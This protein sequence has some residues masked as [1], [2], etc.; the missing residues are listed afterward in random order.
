MQHDAGTRPPPDRA[1][2]VATH[3]LSTETKVL[4]ERYPAVIMPLMDRPFIQHVIEHLVQ[5]GIRRFDVIISKRPEKIEALLDD[6]RRW[7]VTVSYH[8]IKNPGQPYRPLLR[9]N[10]GAGDT[11]P[12]LLVHADRWPPLDWHGLYRF[13]VSRSPQLF[14]AIDPFSTGNHNS[15]AWSGWAL[16]PTR[17]LAKLPFNIDEQGLCDYLAGLPG[18]VKTLVSDQPVLSVRSINDLFNSHRQ[19]LGGRRTDVSWAGN[20]TE[21]GIWL[22]RNV[23]LHPAARLRAPLYV[24]ENCRIGREASLGPYASVGR[25]CML[26]QHATVRESIIF[27]ESYVG[28]NLELDRVVVDRNCLVNLRLGSELMVSEAFLLG[29]LVKGTVR[30]GCLRMLSRSVAALLLL[31]FSPW[32]LM[33]W[34]YSRVRRRAPSFYRRTFVLLPA[35]PDPAE[36]RLGNQLGIC[37]NDGRS[38]EFLTTAGWRDLLFRIVP[39]LVNVAAGSL[40]F[41][42]VAPRH[43]NQILRLPEDWRALYLKCRA[44]LI[45]EAQVNFGAAATRD[46]IYSADAV[47]SVSHGVVYD[48][49]LIGRY[50]LQL[51]G[52]RHVQG[53]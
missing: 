38:S 23:R 18:S 45:S 32:L 40:G 1:I 42:G 26:D 9:L 11:P 44:G 5:A 12:M 3:E 21:P 19:V 14:F 15:V 30:H 29:S 36:W 4:A 28:E 37:A 24:G 10:C 8:L 20:Q 2:L 13:G 49:R 16:L 27:P 47:Y 39:A 33:V 22:S 34:L 46:Q 43:R 31:C 25:D 7:G 41:A 17:C 52:W 51:L 35:A 6:G 48:L 50:M 53:K